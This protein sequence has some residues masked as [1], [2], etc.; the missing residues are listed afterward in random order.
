MLDVLGYILVGVFGVFY[1]TGLDKL[2]AV[3]II[4]RRMRKYG[5]NNN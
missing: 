4:G 2:V 5:C 1:T 3:W